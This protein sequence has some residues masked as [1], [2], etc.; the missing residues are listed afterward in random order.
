MTVAAMFVVAAFILR[1]VPD[2]AAIA[3]A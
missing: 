1:G 3:R 2:R